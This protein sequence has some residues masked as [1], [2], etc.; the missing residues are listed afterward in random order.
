[1]FSIWLES[2]LSWLRRLRSHKQ[3]GEVTQRQRVIKERRGRWR[4]PTGRMKNSALIEYHFLMVC[5][6]ACRHP[7]LWLL[8]GVETSLLQTRI[9]KTGVA[10]ASAD[11]T[12]RENRCDLCARQMADNPQ[13]TGANGNGR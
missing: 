8:W 1:M 10:I 6:F 7:A 9:V 5:P 2:R 12:K 13:A 11:D 4:G 3:L